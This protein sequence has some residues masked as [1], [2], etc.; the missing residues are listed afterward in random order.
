MTWEATGY[1]KYIGLQSP[2]PWI[3]QMTW[4][5]DVISSCDYCRLSFKQT[6]SR[7]IRSIVAWKQCSFTNYG[8]KLFLLVKQGRMR[9]HV[10]LNKAAT[11]IRTSLLTMQFMTNI[12][13][14]CRVTNTK[15]IHSTAWMYVGSSP[16]IRNPEIQLRPN[17]GYRTIAVRRGTL[18]WENISSHYTHIHICAHTCIRIINI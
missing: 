3:N 16:K 10:E 12:T 13:T 4:W 6:I 15:K 14:P 8:H 7:Y 17:T 5:G 11:A 18:E 2:W 9:Y 1:R